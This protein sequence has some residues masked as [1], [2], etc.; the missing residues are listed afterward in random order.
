M[1]GLNLPHAAFDEQLEIRRACLVLIETI[2]ERVLKV[3]D[4]EV[5]GAA[6]VFAVQERAMWVCARHRFDQ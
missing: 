1:L 6:V 3:R 4:L 5:V 2:P